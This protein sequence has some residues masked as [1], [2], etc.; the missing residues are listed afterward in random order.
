M[1]AQVGAPTRENF[2]AC[3]MPQYNF[4][5]KFLCYSVRCLVHHRGRFYV[6]RGVLA[7]NNNIYLL[8][9]IPTWYIEPQMS[10]AHCSPT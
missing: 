7:K 8:L 2:L 6:A 5:D 4:L 3:A 1:A 10:F 9:L